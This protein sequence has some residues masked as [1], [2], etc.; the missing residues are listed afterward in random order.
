MIDWPESY[1]LVRKEDGHEDGYNEEDDDGDEEA[2]VH[3]ELVSL[4][5]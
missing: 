3:D 4:A 2:P 5:L 1:S